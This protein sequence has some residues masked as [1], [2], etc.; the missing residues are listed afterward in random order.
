MTLAGGLGDD[1]INLV[2][3]KAKNNLI[4]YTAGDGNDVITGFNATSTLQIGDGS[5][6]YSTQV[7]GKDIIITVGDDSI[8]LIG[9]ANLKDINISGIYEDNADSDTDSDSD[10]D[11][12]LKENDLAT[13]DYSEILEELGISESSANNITSE[14]DTSKAVTMTAGGGLAVV[15]SNVSVNIIASSGEDT[16]IAKSG[17]NVSFNLKGSKAADKFILGLSAKRPTRLEVL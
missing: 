13:K 5:G 12:E 11:D 8:S 9:V 14:T 15:D 7:S 10:S 1:T 17:A 3:R 16:L 2:Q 6:T 4:S